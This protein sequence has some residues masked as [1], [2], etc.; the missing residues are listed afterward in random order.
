MEEYNVA[1]ERVVS[2]SS[3]ARLA[4]IQVDWQEKGQVQTFTLREY[5]QPYVQSDEDS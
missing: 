1:G 5:F 3:E 2:E 4:P